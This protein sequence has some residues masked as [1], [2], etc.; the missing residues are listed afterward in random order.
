MNRLKDCKGQKVNFLAKGGAPMKARLLYP[1]Y[2]DTLWRF[3]HALKFF[4][5]EAARQKSGIITAM[6][7]RL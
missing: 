1:D 2:P 4:L 3:K 5:K 7:G 6:V